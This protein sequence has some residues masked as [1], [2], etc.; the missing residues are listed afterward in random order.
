MRPAARLTPKSGSLRREARRSPLARIAVNIAPVV[1]NM[2]TQG[3]PLF[4]A[5]AL[6]AVLAA[7]FVLRTGSA[8]AVTAL[9]AR[10]GLTAVRLA[11]PGGMTLLD[12]FAPLLPSGAPFVI[13][14]PA[15][16]R[17]GLSPCRRQG[18]REGQAAQ[19]NQ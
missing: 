16:I 12:L 10:T 9:L 11:R 14:A 19:G 6:T 7:I 1:T 15:A 3:A 13:A 2:F 4:R 18:L 8:A 17:R 5:H